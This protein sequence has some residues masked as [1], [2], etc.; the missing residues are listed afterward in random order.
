MKKRSYRMIP[1]QNLDVSRLVADAA[2]ERV[3][4]AVDVAKVDMVGTFATRDLVLT[5]VRWKN[6]EENPHAIEAVLALRAAGL[7]VDVA[8]EPS[9]TYGDVLRHQFGVR[10]VVVYRVSGKRTHDAREVYDGVPSLH[11]AKSAAIIAKLH[12]EG[13]STPWAPIAN[14]RRSLQAAVTVLDMVKSHYLQLIH[15]LEG[16]LARYWPEVTQLVE[17]TSAT[18]LALLA[19]IGGPRDVT[20]HSAAA[21]SLMKGMSRGLMAPE[22]IDAVLASAA[23]SVGTPLLDEERAALMKLASHAHRAMREHKAEKHH[24]E[25]LSESESAAQMA[26]V[27]GKAT[28][29][30]LT[31]DIGDPRDF[32]ST[33]AY[34]KAGG[35]NLKETSS[36]TKKGKLSI[37]KR[38]P[39]RTRQWLWLA[40]LRLIMKDRVVK[41]WFEKKV[42]RDGG[43][44]AG[45]IVAVMRK[46]M[47][48]LFHVARGAPFDSSKLFDTSRLDLAG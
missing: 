17:L 29:A 18:L 14:S 40:A 20:T 6:T 15:M 47:K 44:K 32:T 7:E 41:A 28:A 36:G 24:V 42:A 2:G 25:Q 4:F 9:G 5:T 27:V 19:R 39:S 10:G 11:D 35:M 48:A 22:K 38:G 23:A 30:V 21:Q 31:A 34:V 43:K 8:M 12:F 45:A 33:G 16:M 26:A 46:L 13:A 1:I 37:T 3:V